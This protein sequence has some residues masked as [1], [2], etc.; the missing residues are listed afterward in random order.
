VPPLTKKPDPIALEL[1][2][3]WARWAARL[4]RWGLRGFAATLLESGGAFATLAAQ[5]LYISQPMLDTWLS[6]R[7]LR[8]LAQTLEDPQQTA[9]FATFLRAEPK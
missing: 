6:P 2:P 7:G 4:H 1:H 3:E 5:S 9:A 8:S